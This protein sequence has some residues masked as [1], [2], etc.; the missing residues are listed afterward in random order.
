M[1]CSSLLWILQVLREGH[2]FVKYADQGD[3]DIACS[4]KCR[5]YGSTTI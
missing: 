2:V 1:V 4:I 5:K 3:N